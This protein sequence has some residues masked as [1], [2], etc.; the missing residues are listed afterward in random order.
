MPQEFQSDRQVGHGRYVLEKELGRGGMGV[1][2]LAKDQELGE[3]VALKFM[4]PEIRSDPMALDD[5]RRE[6]LKSRRLTHPNIARIHDFSNV[7]GEAPF[8]SME[9]M[10]GPNLSQ[11]QV[12]QPDRVFG[13][14]EVAPWVKQLCDALQYAHGENV[15]HRDLKPGNLMIDAKGRLKLCDFGLAASVADSMSRVSRDMGSSGTPPYMSPQQLDGRQPTPSDDVYGLGAT[16]YEL[17]TS[18]PPFYS[19]D[20]PHQIREIEAQSIGER[21]GELGIV[22]EIPAEV[23]ALV[24]SCLAKEPS[25]RPA[26]AAEVARIAFGFAVG[27]VA[28][29]SAPVE[30]DR[31]ADPIVEPVVAETLED[32]EVPPA[33]EIS[34]L[35]SSQPP[36]DLA[37]RAR[38]KKIVIWTVAIL[39]LLS[40]LKKAQEKRTGRQ[41]SGAPVSAAAGSLIELNKLEGCEVYDYLESQAQNQTAI[42]WRSG[43]EGQIWTS[44]GGVITARFTGPAG[45]EIRRT[46]L[47]FAT[48][49]V[50][51]FEL[52]FAYRTPD[53]GSSDRDAGIFYRSRPQQDTHFKGTSIWIESGEGRFYSGRRDQQPNPRDIERVEQ[54]GD[55]DW[56]SDDLMARVQAA[57]FMTGSANDERRGWGVIRADGN[58]IHHLCSVP[59]RDGSGEEVRYYRRQLVSADESEPGVIAL[60]VWVRGESERVFEFDSLLLR[61]FAPKP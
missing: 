51:D 17:L 57:Q 23:V 21:L 14:K 4:P 47:S 30:P 36:A 61:T 58:T 27:G 52:A 32:V 8:I 35:E 2:W 40:A 42:P 53:L 5:M 29:I 33:T 46:Y 26:S 20:I 31:A 16:I 49:T 43:R 9:F 59:A 28:E 11:L 19:G 13:W 1:V 7:E 50:W 44:D 37:K 10:A 15:I 22:N 55:R 24:M 60:E 54:A 3:Q 48:H 45:N 38:N 56:F 34:D 25:G 6:T 18:K 41:S 39:V 12:G